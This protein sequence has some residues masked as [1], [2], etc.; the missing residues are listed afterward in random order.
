VRTSSAALDFI[1]GPTEQVP[2]GDR[3]GVPELLSFQTRASHCSAEREAPIFLN[4]RR[5]SS[6][7]G[8]ML[9]CLVLGHSLSLAI[10]EHSTGHDQIAPCEMR[11]LCNSLTLP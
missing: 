3:I 5:R 7:A 11:V 1:E 9:R 8:E 4:A 6:T 10:G 2:T